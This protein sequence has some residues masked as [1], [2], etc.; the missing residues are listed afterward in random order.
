[1]RGDFVV[2]AMPQPRELLQQQVLRAHHLRSEGK[3]LR[4][5]LGRLRGRALLRRL[6]GGRRDL[7]GSGAANIC[8]AC[9]PKT[10]GPK[11][12]GTMSDGCGKML[13]CPGCTAAGETCGGAGAANVCAVCTKKTCAA[14][15]CGKMS[16]GC[17]GE[18]DCG[19]ACPAMGD[20][21]VVCSTKNK[22]CIPKS[23]GQGNCGAPRRRVRH[24]A[25]LRRM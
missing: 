24:H 22:C 21:A 18:L 15:S 8:G 6:F 2:L 20:A 11:S 13:T 5:D 10:C 4:Q 12:C 3:E 16:D 19:T 7:R 25:S 14:D 9:V 17:G 1:M 23:C